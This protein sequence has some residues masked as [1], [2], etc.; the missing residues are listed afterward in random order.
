[1]HTSLSRMAA[2]A[3]ALFVLGFVPAAAAAVTP[4]ENENL[5]NQ[6]ITNGPIAEY[7][8][9]TAVSIAWSTRGSAQMA[10]RVGTDP[11]HLETTVDA[12]QRGRG[13]CHHARVDGLKPDTTYYFQVMDGDRT[14]GEVGV[15]QTL[16]SGATPVTRKVIV[17]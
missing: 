11:N 2:F 7:L 9:D 3:I 17:P 8:A 5:E 15:F 13:R 6:H 16:H 10:I 12:A 1:M 4:H 14:V